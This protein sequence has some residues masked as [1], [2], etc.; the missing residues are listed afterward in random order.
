MQQFPWQSDDP[1]DVEQTAVQSQETIK[2]IAPRVAWTLVDADWLADEMTVTDGVALSLILELAELE[3]ALAAQV[4]ELPWVVDELSEEETLAVSAIRDIAAENA[5]VAAGISQPGWLSEGL[6]QQDEFTLSII[7]DIYGEGPD[8]AQR[9]AASPEIADCISGSE[10]AAFTGSE[11]YYLEYIER[12]HP[13]LAKDSQ[14][15]RLALRQRQSGPAVRSGPGREYRGPGVLASHLLDDGLTDLERSALADLAS[16]PYIDYRRGV[17]RTGCQPAVVGRRHH[18]GG[19]ADSR[20]YKHD[21][22]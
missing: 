7:R 14:G 13:D 9:M 21:S 22:R 1:T 3:P 4:A 10:L 12:D 19:R 15:L 8:L 5:T 17:G 18:G 6:D 11:N 2:G 20:L 16:I